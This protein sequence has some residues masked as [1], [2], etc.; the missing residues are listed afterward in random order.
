MIRSRELVFA[1]NSLLRVNEQDVFIDVF[2]DELILKILSSLH[3]REIL[4]VATLNKKMSL[5]V[6]DPELLKWVIYRDMTF[7]PEDWTTHFGNSNPAALEENQAWNLLP[8]DIGKIYK[9]RF[10]K[11]PK[12]K[13]GETHV[14]VWK[15]ANLSINNYVSLVE[16]ALN[17]K[18]CYV[19]VP[20]IEDELTEKAE[21][22]VMTRK[23]IPKSLDFSKHEKIVKKQNLKNFESCN[24]P[25]VIESMICA[26]SIFL[27]FEITT[28]YKA[29]NL[30]RCLESGEVPIIVRMWG[31]ALECCPMH[32]RTQGLVPVWKF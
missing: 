26:V 27:K 32:V 20:K 13:L 15:P 14:I 17:L 16:T 22:L 8:N 1:E 28:L 25:K 18:Y 19:D 23:I 12:K 4:K 21:W 9:N 2:P 3:F 7:N 11:F 6:N 29:E 24:I 10:L 31:D 30:T 5:L